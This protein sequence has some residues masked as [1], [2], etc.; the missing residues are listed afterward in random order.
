MERINTNTISLHFYKLIEQLRSSLPSEHS[1]NPLHIR[2]FGKHSPKGHRWPLQ[3][4]IEDRISSLEITYS[5][6]ER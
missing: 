4:A 5:I 3:E 6:Q 1:R 2:D